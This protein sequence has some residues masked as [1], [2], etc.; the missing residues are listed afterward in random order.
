MHDP[1]HLT[2][3]LNQ[4]RALKSPSYRR[5]HGTYWIE[6]I[7][8]FIQAC[9]SRQDFELILYSPVLLKNQL[10]EMLAHRRAACGVPRLRVSPEQFRSVSGAQ[11]ASGIGAVI[12]QRW[13]PLVEI[14][15]IQGKYWLVIDSLCNAG[16]LGT[17][18]RTAEAAGAAGAIFVGE[19]C[20]PFD[21]AVVRA[22]MGG[23]F[24]LPLTSASVEELEVWA[25]D[26]GVMLVGL[27]P[28][29]GRPWTQLPMSASYALL[30]GDERKG[31][32]HRMKA[33]CQAEVEL[34]MAGRADSLNVGIAAGVMMYELVRRQL[35]LGQSEA[36]I[37]PGCLGSSTPAVVPTSR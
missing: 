5:T 27:S 23:L 6:G 10:A 8:H 12:K 3:V 33:L 24:H 20:D 14:T 2:R 29:A 19:G 35:A 1:Q 11:R 18:L 13:T 32:S 22:S 21:P 28:R 31:L 4:I 25:Q 16:N 7:R 15:V 36:G 34:P 9:D 17:I 30:I 37:T 26:N